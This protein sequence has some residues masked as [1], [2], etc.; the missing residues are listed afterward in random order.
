MEMTEYAVQNNKDSHADAA[1]PT[2]IWICGQLSGEQS[3]DSSF[4]C[5]TPIP[6]TS[7]FAFIDKEGL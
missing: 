3:V 7:G 1:K 6:E 5:L 4:A 2:S